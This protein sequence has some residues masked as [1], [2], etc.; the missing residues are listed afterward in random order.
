M[1]IRLLGFL[2]AS[3]DRRPMVLGAQL[4]RVADAVS[5]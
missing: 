2:E 3:V 1:K 4:G 5:P